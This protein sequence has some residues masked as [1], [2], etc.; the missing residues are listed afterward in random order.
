MLPA[1]LTCLS[2]LK[3]LVGAASMGVVKRLLSEFAC[4]APMHALTTPLQYAQA[5]S[6]RYDQ[7]SDAYVYGLL[8]QLTW[9][10]SLALIG[11]YEAPP[12]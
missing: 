3:S 11:P 8:R 6:L 2:S 5:V 9:L 4:C 12:V 7:S 1:G 10:T